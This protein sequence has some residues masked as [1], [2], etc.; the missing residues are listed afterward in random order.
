[1]DVGV[2]LIAR[3]NLTITLG[4]ISNMRKNLSFFIK[5]IVL[6]GF[7]IFDFY[8]E[9]FINNYSRVTYNVSAQLVYFLLRCFIFGVLS[10]SVVLMIF[11]IG[12]G[13]RIFIH[14]LLIVS[15]VVSILNIF[16]R[17]SISVFVLI[18]C[19]MFFGALVFR[20]KKKP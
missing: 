20:M 4:R 14:I 2:S 5:I 1:M 11:E 18:L 16:M 7:I 19:G 10:T 17:H 3:C 9:K 6:Y 13:C 15:L 12:K 8:F